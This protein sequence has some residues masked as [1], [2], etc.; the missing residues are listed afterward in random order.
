MEF[1]LGKMQKNTYVQMF[2][3]SNYCMYVAVLF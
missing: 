3:S 1:S 2:D